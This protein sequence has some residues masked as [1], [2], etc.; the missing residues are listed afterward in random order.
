MNEQSRLSDVIGNCSR[1]TWNYFDETKTSWQ[2]DAT[3]A[4][5]PAAI[6]NA[7]NF[8]CL[9]PNNKY[10][11]WFF[12]SANHIKFFTEC[13]RFR[14]WITRRSL[15]L[16]KQFDNINISIR[17]AI[18]G[19]LR[20]AESSRTEDANWIRWGV[21]HDSLLMWSTFSV[22][23]YFPCTERKST[24]SCDYGKRAHAI[25]FHFSIDKRFC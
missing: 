14:R 23:R 12:Q 16:D 21:K 1:L 15:R 22:S 5:P 9:Q 2:G 11:T 3:S 20:R 17:A 19:W 24:K 13:Q 10:F 7:N 18:Q 6:I 25:H 4:Q 8:F